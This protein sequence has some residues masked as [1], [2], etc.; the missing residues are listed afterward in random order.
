MK[1]ELTAEEQKE[2][3]LN[4]FADFTEKPDELLD[5]IE[6]TGMSL[7]ALRDPTDLPELIAGHYRCKKGNY[8]V[9]RA[10]NDL[11]T[12]PPVAS[13]VFSRLATREG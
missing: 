12:W 4:I 2:L 1:H 13:A 10:A 9:D 3:I 5:F 7:R 11:L 6:H 8:D